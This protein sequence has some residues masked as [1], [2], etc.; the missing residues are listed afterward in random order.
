MEK[1]FGRENVSQIVCFAEKHLPQY[2][3]IY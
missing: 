2:I 3:G 1:V